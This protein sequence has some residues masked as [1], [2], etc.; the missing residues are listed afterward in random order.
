MF[1]AYIVTVANEIGSFEADLEIPSQIPFGQWKDK[2]LA[3]TRML[4][5]SQFQG[6]SGC[7]MSFNGRPISDD[8]TLAQIGAFEGSRLI[9][10][11]R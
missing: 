5:G 7:A 8:E 4:D 10:V 3:I 6:W 11:R 1:D 2:V 9:L